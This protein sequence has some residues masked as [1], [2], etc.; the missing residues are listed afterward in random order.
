MNTLAKLLTPLNLFTLVHTIGHTFTPPL[1]QVF[2]G[3]EWHV[4]MYDAMRSSGWGAVIYKAAMLI[5][6]R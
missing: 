1:P 3:E 2:T 6:G 5:V 4:V